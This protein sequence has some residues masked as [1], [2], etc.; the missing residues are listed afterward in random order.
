MVPTLPASVGVKKPFRSPT[1][2][3]TK[4]ARTTD[5]SGRESDPLFPGGLLAGR[6]KRRTDLSPC[7]KS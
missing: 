2:M 3:S 7:R 6:S 4:T 5:T 1:I